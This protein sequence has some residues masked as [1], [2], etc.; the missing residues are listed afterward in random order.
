VRAET[1]PEAH[2]IRAPL[3]KVAVAPFRP[4]E[5]LLREGAGRRDATPEALIARQ[6]AEALAARGIEVVAP[7]NVR[8]ALGLGDASLATLDPVATAGVA[9]AEFGADAVLMGVAT[10]F[11]ERQGEAMGARQPASVAF[12]VTLHAAP[13]G[14]RLW[15]AAFDETQLAMSDNL[16]V[17]RHYPGRGT[18]W[19]SA[20]EFTRWG[21]QQ[22]AAAF[23][24][25]P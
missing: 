14:R 10:R 7:E 16:F 15:T 24:F 5:R 25:A 19:L 2:E 3:E 9:H 11:R 18:R 12:N 1:L 8:R 23:P 20:E 13:S 6:L 22:V 4:S 21:A 17:T